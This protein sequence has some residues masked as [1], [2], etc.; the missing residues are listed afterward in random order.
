M[1][2]VGHDDQTD[3]GNEGHAHGERECLGETEQ[4]GQVHRSALGLRVE[5]QTN[6][7]SAAAPPITLTIEPS[8]V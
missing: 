6:S 8:R 5:S 2:K 3:V 7:T 4:Q 1:P